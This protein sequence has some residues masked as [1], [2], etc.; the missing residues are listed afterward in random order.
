MLLTMCHVRQVNNHGAIYERSKTPIEY[1][2]N[3][4]Q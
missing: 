2:I 3:I 4:E 1:Q